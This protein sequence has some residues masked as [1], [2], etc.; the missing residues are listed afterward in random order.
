MIKIIK[1][2]IEEHREFRSQIMMLAKSDLIATYRG[3]ALGWAWAFV[4]P[5]I[6]L[7]VFWFAFTVGL[8]HGKPV[9]GFPYLL[10]LMAGFL[11]WFYMRDMITGGASC[12]RKY[13][14]LVTKIKFP[15][16]IIPTFTSISNFAVHIAITTVTIIVFCLFGKF[17][18]IYY[19]QIPFYMLLMFVFYEAWSLFAGMLSSVSVDFLN[20]VKSFVQALFWMSGVIYNVDKIHNPTVRVILKFNPIT[21]ISGGYRKAFIYKEWFWEDKVELL[22]YTTT[23]TVVFL[24]ALWAYSKLRKEIPDVL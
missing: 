10:W 24:L 9:N 4:K 15:I 20:L 17:P 21:V 8:R 13:K 23:F 1:L 12:I 22:G 18:D 3:A 6:H 19:L 2:I 14:H 5:I 7:A 11:P 16:S